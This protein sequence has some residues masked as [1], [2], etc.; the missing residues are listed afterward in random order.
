MRYQEF[1]K[2]VLLAMA[3]AASAMALD[4]WGA[5]VGIAAEER[6][7]PAFEAAVTYF[8][9]SPSP[10]S[11]AKILVDFN[12]SPLSA[13]AGAQPP[14]IGFLAAVFQRF[15]DQIDKMIPAGLS[16]ATTWV[17]GVALHLAGQ[18]ARAKP[19]FQHLAANGAPAPDFDRIPSSLDAVAASGSTEFDL[20]WGASFATG[21]RRYCSKILARFAALANVDG[22]AE[23]MVAIVKAISAGAQKGDSKWLVDKRGAEKAR[24]L[25]IVS[26][27][28][29]SLHS[30]A[31]QHD[32][33]RAVVND[34][35]Q[36]HPK[37]PASKALLAL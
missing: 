31:R 17:T 16:P 10:E 37:E 2:V 28:L 30:N 20:L 8:Y 4:L 27:A 18:D 34:Y 3:V 7:R 33:V 26:S 15:P 11:V 6:Q 23:D 19:L 1:G 32:F 25:A 35:I 5:G 12:A 29:W 24:E 13:N 14:M 9:K 21:D 36:A 22:N